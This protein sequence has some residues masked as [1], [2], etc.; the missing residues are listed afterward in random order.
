M[1]NN[2]KKA[3]FD[4]GDG[5][6]VRISIADLPERPSKGDSQDNEKNGEGQETPVAFLDKPLRKT[7]RGK[8][9][10]TSYLYVLLFAAVPILLLLGVPFLLG[11]L[12]RATGL[13]YLSVLGFIAGV[14]ISFVAMITSFLVI[15]NK[16]KKIGA[17]HPDKKSVTQEESLFEVRKLTDILIILIAIQ[18]LIFPLSIN[19]YYTL[20]ETAVLLLSIA[21]IMLILAIACQIIKRKE[22]YANFLYELLLCSVFL[23]GLI[24][25]TNRFYNH[26]YFYG[27]VYKIWY[28]SWFFVPPCLLGLLAFAGHHVLRH[29]KKSSNM[30]LRLSSLLLAIGVIILYIAIIIL[31]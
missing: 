8:K 9:R 6:G 12:T 4:N 16:N 11:S 22:A 31:R 7:A 24:P 25:I 21:S 14:P 13:I 10:K 15:Y 26:D 18:I 28:S 17:K 2:T 1:D 3:G 20:A 29:F 30:V 27:V 23:S 5:G 19:S